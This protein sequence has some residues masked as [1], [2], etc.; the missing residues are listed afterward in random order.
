MQL[1]NIQG[2]IWPGFRKDHQAFVLVRFS[3]KE[4]GRA[5]LRGMEPEI[6]SAEEVAAFNRL[7]GAIWKRRGRAREQARVASSTW[8]NL[9]LSWEGLGLLAAEDRD[10]FSEE[11]REPF[12]WAGEGADG[13]GVHALVL[14]AADRRE[15]LEAELTHQ[16][17]RLS[18][19]G[20][21][22][23]T[24]YRGA[25]LPGKM[26]G[27]EHFGFRDGIAQPRIEGVPDDSPRGEP[28]VKP[29]EFILGY[30]NESGQRAADGPPWASD[31]SFLVFWR[32][33]QHVAVFRRAMRDQAE[34]LS[35]ELTREQL[36]A[37]LMGRWPSGELVDERIQPADPQLP[38]ARAP[39][40]TADEFRGDAVGARFPLCAHIRRANPRD[41]NELNKHRLLRRGIPYGEP[42]AD[43]LLVDD[44]QDRGLLFL[45]YQASIEEQFDFIVEQ[46]L[47]GGDAN[48]PGGRDAILGDP[49][50]GDVTV[51]MKG[52]S[53]QLTLPR[54]VT[55]LEQGYFF[56][57][58]ISALR[59]L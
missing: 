3:E 53:I 54:F 55:R 47:D 22:E 24:T 57:P 42:L 8:V 10:A 21:A 46:W 44:G 45:A 50:K 6:A 41:L 40:P 43:G 20:I 35:A 28:G 25:T 29:G 11:F 9:A 30:E 39:V 33:R 38:K 17:K 1:D 15:D 19:V 56:A 52:G 12:R 13:G 7:F 26:R 5:W 58:S 4:S 48:F 31:G 14:L 32:L 37:K 59:Q 34:K 51:A 18:D 36:A 2:N 49:D 27:H 23:I 16:R